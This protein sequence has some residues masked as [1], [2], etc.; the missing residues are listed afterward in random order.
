MLDWAGA[1]DAVAIV[2]SLIDQVTIFDVGGSTKPVLI[3]HRRRLQNIMDSGSLPGK[4][5]VHRSSTL[6][7]KVEVVKSMRMFSQ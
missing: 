2:V 7:Q 3:D 5:S 1:V 4:K 6:R